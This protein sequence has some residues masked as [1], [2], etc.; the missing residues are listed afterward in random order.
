M[1]RLGP[2]AQLLGLGSYLATCIAGGPTLGYFIDRWLGTEPAFTL[3]GLAL[4][5]VIAF[6]G[7]YRMV[8]ATLRDLE[9]EAAR[10]K[11]QKQKN[12]DSA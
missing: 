4:G 3:I 9:R 7:A 2:V 6:V 12:D 1:D 8:T 10:Q 5:L 11:R